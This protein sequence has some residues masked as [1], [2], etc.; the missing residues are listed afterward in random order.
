[1]N[2]DLQALEDSWG[3]GGKKVMFAIT[4]ILLC[5]MAWAVLFA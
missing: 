1:M 3:N 4:I 2:Y 5:L